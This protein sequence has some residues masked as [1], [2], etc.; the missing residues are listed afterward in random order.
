MKILIVVESID[1][2]ANSGSKANVSLI[3][4]LHKAGYDLKVYHY[5]RK[6]I[7]LAGI[8]CVPIK[9]QKWNLVYLL[10]KVQLR[11]KMLTGLNVNATIEGFFGFSLAFFNDSKSIRR[12]LEK[13]KCF[14]PDWVLTLSYASSFRS[15]KALLGMPEWHSRWL[16]YVHDP[17]PMHSYPRPY[18]WVEPG[19][20]YKRSFF[21]KIVRN[22]EYLLYPSKL[23]SEWMQGYYSGQKNEDII[24]PHQISENP[25]DRKVMKSNFEVNYFTVLHAGNMMNGRNPMTLIRAFEQFF[26]Q[27][28]EAKAHARLY[29][30][31]APSCY[32]Q[33]IEEKQKNMPQLFLSNV[34]IPFKEVLAMQE[35]AS[36]NVIL[37]ALGPI[38][39]FLPGKFAHCIQAQRPI[40]LLG[41]FYSESKRLLGENYQYCSP[42]NDIELIQKHITDLYQHWLRNDK[43]IKMHREDLLYYLSSDYLKE[44]I[45]NLIYK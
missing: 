11:F 19:H 34:Y 39:P 7:S 44:V 6:S 31:G 35:E 21:L 9:E 40:L 28:P 13:E 25:I 36:V 45:D 33:A 15:H 10:S 12:A 24:V 41:P 17:Y 3:K 22:S 37:E 1:I 29:F 23:L 2:N 4:N 26:K 30:I 43:Q 14:Q 20:Q 5:S 42:I 18:D 32:D 27:Y 38:S 16:A 8:L